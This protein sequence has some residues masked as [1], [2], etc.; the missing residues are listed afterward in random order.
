MAWVRP[1]ESEPAQ[2]SKGLSAIVAP[3]G[4]AG[5]VT[6]NPAGTSAWVSRARLA[7]S[8]AGSPGGAVVVGTG[9]GVAV[10]V[11]D[12]AAVVVVVEDSGI[13]NQPSSAAPEP[14]ASA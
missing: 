11:V 7:T 12:V 14:R 9:A 6:V 13:G 1:T 10:V 4:G 2:R 8:P 5:L 3:S